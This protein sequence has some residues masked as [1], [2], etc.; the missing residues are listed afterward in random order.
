MKTSKRLSALCMEIVF[1]CFWAACE[2]EL[3]GGPEGA[4]SKALTRCDS[5]QVALMNYIHG[6][7]KTDICHAGEHPYVLSINLGG[8][9][10]TYG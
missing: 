4:V 6:L 9:P 2:S 8:R 3:D 5:V 10:S 1:D 7:C